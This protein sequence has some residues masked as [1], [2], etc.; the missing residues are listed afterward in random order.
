MGVHRHGST[1]VGAVTP[2]CNEC[3]VSLCWDIADHEYEEDKAFWDRWTC[4]DCK[5]VSLKA[6][7]KAQEGIRVVVFGGRDYKNKRRLYEVLDILHW[8]FGFAVVIEGEA[9]GADTLARHWAEDRGLEVDPYPAD[10]SD[11][12]R[13]GAVVRTNRHGRKYDA[14]AGGVRNQRMLDQ[15][16]PD[17]AVA[18]PGGSGTADMK[19]RVKGAGI[20]LIEI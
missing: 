17:L 6:W 7:K 13:P 9:P 5:P 11:I 1:P 19:R 2:I 8:L 4:Q 15:G 3:G 18:F 12:E 10:W 14:A 16:L 20:I